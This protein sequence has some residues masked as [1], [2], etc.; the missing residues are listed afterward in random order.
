M[1]KG[2]VKATVK[3][4]LFYIIKQYAYIINQ[5]EDCQELL[6]IETSK[7]ISQKVILRFF[8]CPKNTKF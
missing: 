6:N 1:L 2:R 3:L 4:C 5:L 7:I 8:R